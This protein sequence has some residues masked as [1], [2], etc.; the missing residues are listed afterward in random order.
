MSIAKTDIIWQEDGTPRSRQFDDVYFSARD[1]LAET[2]HV[3]LNG[4]GAPEVWQGAANF[5]IAETGFGTGLNFIAAWRLW[6][7]TALDNARLHY[8]SAEGWP[9]A[10]DDMAQALARWPE[11][12]AER[13]ALLDAYPRRRPGFHHLVLDGGRVRLTLLFGEAAEMFG[14]LD[15]TVDAWFLDGFAP[16]R[17]PEM[18]RPALFHQVARLSKPSARVAT[19]TVAGV[20]RRGLAEVGFEV[21]KV[22]GFGTK[23]QCLTGIY[24]GRSETVGDTPWFA[25]PVPV[26]PKHVAVIGAGIAGLSAARALLNRGIRVTVLDRAAEPLAEASGNPAAVVEPQVARGGTGRALHEA[27]FL[28]ARRFY[29]N[30]REGGFRACGALHQAGDA[31]AADKFR[32]IIRDDDAPDPL[33]SSARWVEG[34][35][36]LLI[37]DAGIVEPPRLREPLTEGLDLRLGSEVTGLE[38]GGKGWLVRLGFEALT[39]DAVV[40]AGGIGSAAFVHDPALPMTARRGQVSLIPLVEGINHVMSYG[41]YL[42]PAVEGTNGSFHVL[43]ATFDDADPTDEGWRAVTAASHDENR[44]KLKAALPGVA[45]SDPTEWQGRTGLRATTPDRLP[46][47]GGVV[48]EAQFLDAFAPL[49]TGA[50]DA[51]FPPVP[52]QPGLYVLTGLGSR[53]FATAPLLGE[54]IAAEMT[55]TPAPLP[56]SLREA[57]HPARFLVRG[58]KRREL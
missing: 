4:I 16:S 9:M 18:W 49:R 12:A 40:I 27:A 1:G 50:K 23:R 21:E 51:D 8:I 45:V 47:A 56:R 53:G 15:A 32:Q 55:G 44:D 22:P 33:F 39:V 38:R 41:G 34:A 19:F 52:Y 31:D 48:D 29:E 2:R 10:R 3:F 24:Q 7:D 42:T 13:D 6:R 54:L 26:K 30:L 58:L 36:A 5:T 20:V 11:L 28:Y 25:S 37:P 46:V 17:N 35:E 43:G 14:Q 57:I